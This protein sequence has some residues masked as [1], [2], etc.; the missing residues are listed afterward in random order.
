VS[1]DGELGIVSNAVETDRDFREKV[2]DIRERPPAL[3]AEIRE[4]KTG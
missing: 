1:A 3:N 2:L 4:M